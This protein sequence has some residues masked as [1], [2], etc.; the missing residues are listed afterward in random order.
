[1][2]WALARFLVLLVAGPAAEGGLTGPFVEAF[3]EEV[4]TSSSPPAF[5]VLLAESSILA[6]STTELG[7][8]DKLVG[9]G[10]VV[11]ASLSPFMV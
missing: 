1:M 3:D 9:P 6:D 8:S 4:P 11:R 7:F 5:F 10:L 2:F